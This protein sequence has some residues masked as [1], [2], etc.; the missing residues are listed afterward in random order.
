MIALMTA[1]RLQV[2]A[3]FTFVDMVNNLDHS[4]RFHFFLSGFLFQKEIDICMVRHD[5]AHSGIFR[6]SLELYVISCVTDAVS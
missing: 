3:S 5:R 1:Y 6:N 4:L 2:D